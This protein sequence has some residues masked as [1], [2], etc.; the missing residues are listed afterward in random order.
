[1]ASWLESFKPHLVELAVQ[2][3]VAG[4]IIIT[5]VAL[6][7]GMSHFVFVTY[8]LAVATLVIA[9][10]AY[11]LERYAIIYMKGF[12]YRYEA[13]N[14]LVFCVLQKPTPSND[15]CR[16]LADFWACTLW[17]SRQ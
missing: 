5:R 8:T 10:V 14:V 9:P 2:I 4:M 1:M 16:L 17:V 7:E 13:P 15:L 11:F 3:C 6:D 12:D